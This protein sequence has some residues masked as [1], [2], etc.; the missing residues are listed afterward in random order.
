M[1]L[2]S[3]AIS[4][5]KLSHPKRL[6]VQAVVALV[7][8]GAQHAGAQSWNYQS[9]GDGGRPYAPGYI[10]LDETGGKPILQMV[11]GTLINCF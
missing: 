10:T 6:L 9:Y 2:A 8:L 1:N 5:F 3:S 4:F 7:A 11:A